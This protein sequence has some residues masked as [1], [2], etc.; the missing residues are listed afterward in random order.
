MAS[1]T[2]GEIGNVINA[3]W[4]SVDDAYKDSCVKRTDAK[5]LSFEPVAFTSWYPQLGAT[6]FVFVW[7]AT[8]FGAS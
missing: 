6:I 2:T 4:C 5:D 7:F 8:L 3:F 1:A